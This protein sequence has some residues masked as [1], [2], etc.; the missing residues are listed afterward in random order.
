M[1]KTFALAI[2]ILTLFAACAASH[3]KQD[4]NPA[5][6]AHQFTNHEVDITWKTEKT[7][8]GVRIDGMLKN[9]RP[10]LPYTSLQL[11]AKALD[12]SGKV[13]GKETKT[14]D[15]RFTGSEPFSMEIPVA[16]KENI[17]Q[18]NFSYSYGTTEDFHRNDFNSAP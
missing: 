5:F 11:T 3:V 2:S 18:I 6:T 10:D 1:L 8:K 14:F 4:S 13:L 15:G 9:V 12:D 7:D 17:K 16:Q